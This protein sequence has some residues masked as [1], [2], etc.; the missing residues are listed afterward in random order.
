[1][2]FHRPAGG[3]PDEPS[4]KFVAYGAL[5]A[6][7]RARGHEVYASTFAF[8][9]PS[10]LCTQTDYEQLRDEI[11]DDLRA[12]MPLD[13]VFHVLHGAQMAVG[14]EDCEGDL[15][16]RTREIVGPD[17][18]VGVEL[19]LHANITPMMVG[20]ANVV[21]ACKHYP[22]TDFDERAVDLFRLGERAARG[23]IR[24][25]TCFERAPM[26]GFYYT[27]EPGLAALNQKAADLEGQGGILS[28][29]LIHGFPWADTRDTSAGVLVVSDGESPL[30]RAT[31]RDLADRFFDLRNETR[32]KFR[33][34]AQTLDH[35]QRAGPAPPGRPFVIADIADN[36]GGGAGSDSTF[37]LEEILKRGMKGVGLAMLWDPMAASFASDAGP[38]ARFSLRLGGKSGPRAGDPLD[39]EARVL[40]VNPSGSQT[41]IGLRTP[42]GL[43]VALEI[44]GVIVV[45]NSNRQQVYSPS[46]F[47]DLGIDPRTLNAVVV[48]SSQHFEDQFKGFAREILYCETPGV[49][50]LRFDPG[51]YR[52]VMRP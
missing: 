34:V 20:A 47:E 9:E 11:L 43:A 16:E 42:L 7:A 18:F 2:I 31:A 5:I 24:P 28:V 38:G 15:L 10:G 25:V 13:M 8:A 48:K 44:A 30:A 6:E 45:V 29:S 12:A 22:H 3:V 46:V 40:A 27:T 50:D 19:D 17:V 1:M 21:L 23:E 26:L 36:A 37:I 35:I 41:G 14:Y 39:V 51:A 52:N 32:S 4:A 33:N 49:L